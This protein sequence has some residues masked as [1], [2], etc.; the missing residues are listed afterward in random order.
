[1]ARPLAALRAAAEAGDLAAMEELG[2]RFYY[3]LRE[4][5]KDD[6]QAVVWRRRAAAGNVARAQSAFAFMHT[7]GEGGLEKSDS[8]AVALYRAAVAAGFVD[9]LFN[10]GCC[11]DDGRGVP[12]DRAEA[13]RL[14]LQAADK[15]HAPAEVNLARAYM[16]GE[17]V[18]QDYAA[19]L[20]FARRAADKGDGGGESNLGA[21]Y[22]NGWGVPQDVREG[23]EWWAK[24]AAKGE[25]A[26][27][28]NLRAR[29][30]AGVPEA[31]AALRRLRLAP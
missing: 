4:A 20:R 31:T 30:A 11:F 17:G 25:E 5:P 24:A 21:L 23:V 15:G 8:K 6:A 19:A 16:H 12:Q 22:A 9:A 29:S 13:V 27:I 14:W 1:M 18:A 26:A 2:E 7:N 3:G 28:K 10:L